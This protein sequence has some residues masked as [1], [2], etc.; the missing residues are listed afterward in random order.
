MNFINSGK[1]SSQQS[2]LFVTLSLHYLHPSILVFLYFRQG[3]RGEDK[4]LRHQL[5][6]SFRHRHGECIF[7]TYFSPSHGCRTNPAHAQGRKKRKR[8]FSCFIFSLIVAF[9]PFAMTSCSFF[10]FAH[11]HIQ[12]AHSDAEVGRVFPY[13]GTVCIHLTIFNS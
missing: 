5:W 13:Y 2:E 6:T 11:K 3:N 7:W 8:S 10:L 1:H 4:H 12:K 9:P